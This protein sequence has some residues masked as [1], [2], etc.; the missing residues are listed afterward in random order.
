MSEMTPSQAPSRAESMNPTMYCEDSPLGW[1]VMY[2]MQR[3][4]SFISFIPKSYNLLP[5]FRHDSDGEE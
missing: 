1:Y 3:L 2:S 5:S 4:T